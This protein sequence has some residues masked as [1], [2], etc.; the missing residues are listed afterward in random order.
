MQATVS[1]RPSLS[2]LRTALLFRSDQDNAWKVSAI[3]LKNLTQNTQSRAWYLNNGEFTGCQGRVD[4][5]NE[6]VPHRELGIDHGID[7]NWPACAGKIELSLRPCRPSWAG[8]RTVKQNVGVDKGDA[9]Y[10]FS[11]IAAR[12]GHD[13]FG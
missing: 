2:L 1:T 9:D 4:F 11:V 3:A 6:L 5:F 10:G 7:Q 8:G 12:Q 13:L